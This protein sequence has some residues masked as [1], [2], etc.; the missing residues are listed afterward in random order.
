MFRYKPNNQ[1]EIFA[2]ASVHINDLAKKER[3]KL[4]LINNVDKSALIELKIFRE[5][6]TVEQSMNGADKK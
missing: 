4:R 2:I 5:N 6:L 1:K 3:R